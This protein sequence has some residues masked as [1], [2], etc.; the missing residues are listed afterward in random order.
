P[1]TQN[2][3][4]TELDGAALAAPT[5]WGT[6]P[7]AGAQVINVNANIVSGGGGGGNVNVTQWNSVAVGS[8]TIY[9]TAPT[10]SAVIG[11]N[12]F[13]TN[14]PAT[15]TIS[16]IVGVSNFPATQASNQTQ[17]AGVA[18]GAPSNYGTS[19]GA[20]SVQGVNAFVTNTVTIS[21]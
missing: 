19:P 20:V 10:G 6:A 17:L 11:V 21:G 8:P 15:Q 12:A 7:A 2:I 3:N 18:L 5:A 9:G 16:G 1:A 4:L 14:L 13:I